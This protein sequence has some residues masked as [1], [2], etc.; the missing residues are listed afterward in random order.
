MNDGFDFSELDDLTET[1]EKLQ[2]TFTKETDKI[3]K[4]AGNTFAR[5]VK[6]GYRLKTK[7]ITGN[8]VKG[9]KA[10]KPFK[11]GRDN[12]QIRVFSSAPHAHLIE[13]GHKMMDKNSQ[14]VKNG[15]SFVKGRRVVE[16]ERRAFESEFNDVIEKLVDEF[17]EV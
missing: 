12:R 15:T 16:T 13:Y 17:L 14:P 5:W 11:Y 4:K 2:V 7:K 10:G 9:V 6:K 3:L 8:L 1:L